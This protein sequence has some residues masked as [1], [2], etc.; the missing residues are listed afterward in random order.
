MDF[1]R[2]HNTLLESFSPE[3]SASVKNDMKNLLESTAWRTLA[4]YI[5]LLYRENLVNIAQPVSSAES[6][7]RQEFEKGRAAAF[8]EL[9][10]L[11]QALLDFCQSNIDIE[12][13]I[14]REELNN[15]GWETDFE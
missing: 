10:S 14:D 12:K 3:E 1:N 9:L 6:I 8:L 11:P 13:N 15:D 5:E 4:Q 2:L 7:Y